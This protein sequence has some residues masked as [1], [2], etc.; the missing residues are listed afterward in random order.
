[1]H[2]FRLRKKVAQKYGLLLFK[3]LPKVNNRQMGENSPNLVAL[4]ENTWHGDILSETAC[5]QGD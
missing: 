5:S 2:N 1:M 3:K 4:A